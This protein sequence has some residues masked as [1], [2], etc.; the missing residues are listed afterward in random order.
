MPFALSGRPLLGRARLVAEPGGPLDCLHG[1]RALLAASLRGF[2][3]TLG[4]AEGRSR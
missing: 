3:M 2:R 1:R 4:S